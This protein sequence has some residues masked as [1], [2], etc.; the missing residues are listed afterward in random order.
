[1]QEHITTDNFDSSLQTLSDG[2]PVTIVFISSD[3][4]AIFEN[5]LRFAA[6]YSGK[7]L[8]TVSLDR[9]TNDAM[10][11]LGYCNI[12]LEWDGNLNKLWVERVKIIHLL[13][14]RGLDVVHSDADAVWL[15]DPINYCSKLG[16]DLCFSQGTVWPPLVHE[17]LGAVLCCGFFLIK[18]TTRT[19]KLV[20]EWLEATLID[21]DD[22]RALNELLL[23]KGLKWSYP[24][25]Y[26][27][28]WQEKD[29]RCFNQVQFAS[30]QDQTKVA[31]LPHHL[32]QRIPEKKSAIVKHPLSDKNGDSTESILKQNNCWADS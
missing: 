1:M 14:S 4:L 16:A 8:I 24:E 3:Y 15:K 17:Q 21:G 7:N 20:D 12:Q 19:I 5:W 26:T 22:Q 13:L 25:D 6:P 9:V 10:T 23:T 31:L 11:K 28:N 32:F 27:I 30:L 18:S 29:F 2:K